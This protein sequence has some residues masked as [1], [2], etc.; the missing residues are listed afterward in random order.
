MQ[1]LEG[2]A[3]EGH[4]SSKADMMWW[5]RTGPGGKEKGR[6]R[7]TQGRVNEVGCESRVCWGGERQ[8]RVGK[9]GH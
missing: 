4:S 5:G 6:E 2:G 3:M 7:V 9:G 8:G 1:P